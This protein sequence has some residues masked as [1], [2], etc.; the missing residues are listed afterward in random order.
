MDR[1]LVLPIYIHIHPGPS[2]VTSWA[3]EPPAG[4]VSENF[5]ML[6]RSYSGSNPHAECLGN[7]LGILDMQRSTITSRQTQGPEPA[8]AF[9]APFMVIFSSSHAKQQRRDASFWFEIGATRTYRVKPSLAGQSEQCENAI[10]QGPSGENARLMRDH[11]DSSAGVVN[12]C[13]SY[14]KPRPST[15]S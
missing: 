4:N 15:I 1:P 2:A 14:L 7:P 6:R 3:N 8:A 5:A 11:T 9:C 12:C 13:S 10:A